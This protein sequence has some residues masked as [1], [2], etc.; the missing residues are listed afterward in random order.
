LR[1]LLDE[2]PRLGKPL[3]ALSA[4]KR[5]DIVELLVGLLVGEPRE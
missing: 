4:D 2:S 3:L 1:A 5:A